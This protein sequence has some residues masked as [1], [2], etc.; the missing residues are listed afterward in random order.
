ML[1]KFFSFIILGVLVLSGCANNVE[2]Q[3]SKLEDE[4]K[5]INNNIRL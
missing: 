4:K 1:K 2:K 3:S 5:I